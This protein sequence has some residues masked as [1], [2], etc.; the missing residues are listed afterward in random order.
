MNLERYHLLLADKS[1]MTVVKGITRETIDVIYPRYYPVG[2]VDFFRSHHC[3]D[4]IY[5]DIENQCVYLL[6]DNQVNVGTITI[7][8][9][10]IS[11]LFVLPA[12]Q[13]MGYGRYLLDFAEEK[14]FRQFNEIKVDASLPAKQMYKVRG[15]VET[16][17]HRIATSNGDVLCY[18]VM[19]K[20]MDYTTH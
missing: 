2:A 8:E 18:D 11:R 10:E 17:Y 13:H 16:E 6:K 1:E 15:Y 9:N 19:R 3:D 7:N 14:I 12:Y 4:N 5:K 20:R